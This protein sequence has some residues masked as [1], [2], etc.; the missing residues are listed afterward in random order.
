M[1]ERTV[2]RRRSSPLLVLALAANAVFSGLSGLMLLLAAGPV[3]GW[4]GV[5]GTGILR[6][7]GV[8]L[9]GFGA[10]LF[11][12]ARSEPPGRGLVLAASASDFAWFAGSAVLLLEFPELL[13]P[14]GHAAVAA[15]AVVVAGLGG[16]QLLGL[17][18][19]SRAS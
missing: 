4:L 3:G 5:S 18:R 12:L 15:V 16:A 19:S 11:L 2:V 14:A 9:I 10:G 7:L 8:G 13:T 1:N 6:L 17:R